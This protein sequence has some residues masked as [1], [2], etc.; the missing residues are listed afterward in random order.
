MKAAL[1]V[2]SGERGDQ[3]VPL[4]VIDEQELGVYIRPGNLIEITGLL[5]RISSMA[6]GDTFVMPADIETALTDQL[7]GLIDQFNEVEVDGETYG[8]LSDGDQCLGADEL[9]PGAEVTARRWLSEYIVSNRTLR[10]PSQSWGMKI[11]QASLGITEALEGNSSGPAA[12]TG[13]TAPAAKTRRRR[14][15]AKRARKKAPRR[16]TKK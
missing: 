5:T 2:Q 6:D 10:P 8:F 9:V 15:P 4:K 14:S 3:F 11:L 16:K 7:E 12:G 1:D 13:D